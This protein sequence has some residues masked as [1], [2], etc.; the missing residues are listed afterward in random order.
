M[1]SRCSLWI[2]CVV[3]WFAILM[4]L[5]FFQTAAHGQANQI[6]SEDVAAF[7]VSTY[8]INTK[9]R[10]IKGEKLRFRAFGQIRWYDYNSTRIS[11]SPDGTKLSSSD[12]AKLVDLGKNNRFFDSYY[13]PPF[14]NI[15]N[16]A[17]MGQVGNTVFLI[18]SNMTATMPESGELKLF[19]NDYRPGDNEGQYHVVIYG[20]GINSPPRE[21]YLRSLF[22]SSFEGVKTGNNQSV[23]VYVSKGEIYPPL[24]VRQGE[25]ITF[26][27]SG[28]VI[29][30]QALLSDDIESG[31]EGTSGWKLGR[32]PLYPYADGALVGLVRGHTFLIGRGGTFTMPASGLLRL[33]I[34]DP[35]PSDNE[36][37]FTVEIKGENIRDIFRDP[38][39]LKTASGKAGFVF[40]P[41]EIGTALRIGGMAAYKALTQTARIVRAAENGTGNFGLGEATK[42]QANS[43]GERYVKGDYTIS[44]DGVAWVSKD[45]LRQYRPPTFKPRLGRSQANFQ[46]RSGTSGP[47]EN[48]G[49]L[50]IKH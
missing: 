47:W 8:E 34:N 46:S 45:R 48:N 10:V 22:L 39:W 31:P 28:R 9:S 13:P 37:H 17:L 26:K 18:G 19:V 16:G 36:G 35:Y 2:Q 49:H 42:A 11:S 7:D 20:K 30:Y 14:P 25:S 1:L 23:I 41:W 29:W 12:I 43:A 24:L 3:L 27:A 5:A 50:E 21:E 33:S 6:G 4:N 38:V 32:P 15:N 44:S 40:A